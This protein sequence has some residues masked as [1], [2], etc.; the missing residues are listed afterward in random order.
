M[1]MSCQW[2][3]TSWKNRTIRP[4]AWNALPFYL[5]SVRRPA[6]Y[7]PSRLGGSPP[8]RTLG[9]YLAPPVT[10]QFCR[11]PPACGSR[12]SPFG[13]LPCLAP[14][15]LSPRLPRFVPFPFTYFVRAPVVCGSCAATPGRGLSTPF[16]WPFFRRILPSTI[17]AARIQVAPPCHFVH[18]FLLWNMRKFKSHKTQSILIS[19]YMQLCHQLPYFSRI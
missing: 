7:V 10:G 8:A 2:K 18:F 4:G 11:L 15:P 16:T 17:S 1:V 5:F 9:L 19:S 3:V 13:R 14:S 12:A 6:G